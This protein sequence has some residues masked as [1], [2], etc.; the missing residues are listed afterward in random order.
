MKAEQINSFKVGILI[1]GFFLCKE[2]YFKSTRL[3]DPFIDVIIADSTGEIR[4]KIWKNAYFYNE[5]F[6]VG[7]PVA[8][9]GN[10]INYNNKIEIDIKH[11]SSVK[12]SKY[13][14]YGYTESL[15]VKT[16][17]ISH[18]KL[19]EIINKNIKSLSGDYK[20]IANHLY[21]KYKSKIIS[22]PSYDS[23]YEL[24][25]GFIMKI[26]NIFEINDRLIPLFKYLDKNKVILGILIKDIGCIKY[27]NKDLIL[28]ISKEG[29]FLNVSTLGIN[30]FNSEVSKMQVLGND[31]ELFCQH[32]ISVNDSSLDLEANY[33]NMLFKLD[34]Q[35][36]NNSN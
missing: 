22:L 12:N 19:W 26:A 4:C 21:K 23:K 10:I 36:L 35:L 16:I 5:K 33:I 1:K 18:Q 20:I 3:G 30:L 31:A 24:H 15:I 27:F 34:M 6:S 11:I 25:G 17:D 28:S 14:E 8:I 13:D 29:K 7:D 9:K 32:I 2:K